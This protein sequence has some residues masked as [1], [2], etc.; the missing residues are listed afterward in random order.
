LLIAEPTAPGVVATIAARPQSASAVRHS[1]AIRSPISSP[2]EPAAIPRRYKARALTKRRAGIERQASTG[3][4]RWRRRSTAYALRSGA[5]VATTPGAVV[6]RNE[7]TRIDSVSAADRNRVRRPV[8][9]SRRRST[10]LRVR[11]AAEDS[12]IGHLIQSGRADVHAELAQSLRSGSELEPRHLRRRHLAGDRGDTAVTKSRKVGLVSGCA[13]GLTAMAV[14]GYLSEI[15]DRACPSHS[16]LVTSL[17]ATNLSPLELFATPA[18]WSGCAATPAR[19]SDGRAPS[20][21]RCSPG[22]G[23]TILSGATG[24]Q[25]LMGRN[26][27]ALECSTMGQ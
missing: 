24:E 25:Y 9:W 3:R 7:Q 8:C 14:L 5:I 12:M 1:D 19:S 6:F 23:R 17:F 20:L 21:P 15:R 27:P 26:P 18:R 10:I 22:C 16:L 11:P 13:G 2:L 4:Q